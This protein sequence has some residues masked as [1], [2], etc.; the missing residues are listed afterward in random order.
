V[1]SSCQ[2]QII[3]S[4][5]ESFLSPRVFAIFYNYVYLIRCGFVAKN[6]LMRFTLLAAALEE[7]TSALVL[8]AAFSTPT[9]MIEY[10]K[11]AGVTNDHVT[12]TPQT[13]SIAI[14]TCI[15]QLL[16]TRMATC[17]LDIQLAI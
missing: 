8:S 4:Q 16:L 6:L 1:L 17:H 2:R 7:A 11:I 10:I 14:P 15:Q 12:L 9:A 13:I 5:L 3:I